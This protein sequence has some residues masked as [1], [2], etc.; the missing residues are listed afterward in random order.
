MHTLKA[1]EAF[2]RLKTVRAVAD[3]L[4]VTRSAVSH[5]LTLLEDI[6]GFKVIERAGR[7]IALTARASRYAQD[8]HT[9]LWLLANASD[10]AGS[11]V[12]EGVLRVCST[13]GFASMWLC[14]H[15]GAFSGKYPALNIEIA[16]ARILDDVSDGD[17]DI[18]IA[19]GNGNWPNHLVEHLYDV[20]FLPLCS[21]QLLARAP[22]SRP[23]DLL[24]ATLLHLHRW[25]DWSRWLTLNDVAFP[26]TRAGITFSD[27]M[28]VQTAAIAG[29]GIMMGDDI[30]C[31]DAL[32]GSL[33]L[34][35]FPTRIK[36][37]GSYYLV[38]QRYKPLSP[39]VVAFKR[40][41]STLVHERV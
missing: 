1:L 20:E 2:A 16:T 35:P 15:I 31:A 25:D 7:G 26:S 37:P 27:L 11:E 33:L 34:A 28:L 18:F 5:R 19:F 6:L 32:T 12:V 22:L 41:V 13:A 8:V 36:A 39:A 3:E 21:P 9:S 4:G 24:N 14:N 30:T 40:W 38:S 29:Q 17:A 23:S 10:D